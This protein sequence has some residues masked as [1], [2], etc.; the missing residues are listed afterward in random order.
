M[1]A[2][3]QTQEH[4]G[5][6]DP[7]V[8]A[9]RE[10]FHQLTRIQRKLEKRSK[11]I[12]FDAEQLEEIGIVRGSPFDVDEDDPIDPD[13]RYFLPGPVE[14]MEDGLER[15]R[16][17]V[18]IWGRQSRPWP[19]A[20]PI[21][22]HKLRGRNELAHRHAANDAWYDAKARG[23]FCEVAG[24]SESGWRDHDF[25]ISRKARGCQKS[26]PSP[27]DGRPCWQFWTHGNFYMR[28]RPPSDYP[29]EPDASLY[30][31]DLPHAAVTI[32]DMARP[33]CEGLLRS[34]LLM[35]VC[36]L[37]AQIRWPGMYLDHHVYPVRL[38]P[39]L[40]IF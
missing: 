14:D 5:A 22:N 10:E 31:P 20:E 16:N 15:I 37:K 2:T 17:D 3:I 9:R 35:A 27:E 7:R 34:E 19:Q 40:L 26:W 4:G 28:A 29:S 21:K 11:T 1:P 12:V 32:Y 23:Y 33:P 6:A 30:N 13:P 8:A 38:R 25:I 39:A 36:L 24:W 18:D